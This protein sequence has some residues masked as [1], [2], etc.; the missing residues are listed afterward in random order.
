MSSLLGQDTTKRIDSYLLWEDSFVSIYV[1]S[2]EEKDEKKKKKKDE[3]TI[4]KKEE[5]N[6]MIVSFE[7][8]TGKI[9]IVRK[10]KDERRKRTTTTPATLTNEEDEDERVPLSESFESNQLREKKRRRIS[11]EYMTTDKDL[12][13][14]RFLSQQQ[15]ETSNGGFATISD[16]GDDMSL[17][18][19]P[20]TKMDVGSGRGSSALRLGKIQMDKDTVIVSKEW[21]VMQQV[22]GEIPKA[23]WGHSA[24]AVSNHQVV[25]FGGQDNEEKLVGKVTMFDAM[26]RSYEVPI[27]SDHEP[28]AWHSATFMKKM[29][30]LAVFGGQRPTKD[31]TIECT[32]ELVVLDTEIMLWYPPRVHGKLPAARAGHT[33][34]MVLG[35]EEMFVFGGW[36]GRT[37]Y[38]DLYALNTSRWEWRHVNTTGKA[39]SP[40]VYHTATAIRA[41]NALVV[42]GGNDK[43]RCFNDVVVL[44]KEKDRWQWSRPIVVGTPPRPRCGQ[45]QRCPHHGR[46]P[47]L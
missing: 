30:T 4:E 28:R 27:N 10:D 41:G 17:T 42:F 40:R 5:D 18:L 43:T 35:E 33:A 38:N 32:N 22:T 36:R 34:T 25:L 6:E 7:K 45:A 20:T 15:D 46:R 47:G 11:D 44:T 2:E 3:R 24:T 16:T 12:P 23:R 37:W 19:R 14:Y 9:R 26:K 31:G 13:A 8:F 29:N 39:P 1:V 21:V